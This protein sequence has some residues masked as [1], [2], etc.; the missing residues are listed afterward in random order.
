MCADV[1]L[2]HCGSHP[3]KKHHCTRGIFSVLPPGGF[4]LWL[5]DDFKICCH[6]I[7]VRANNRAAQYGKNE[8]AIVF[9]EVW[10]KQTCF[11]ISGKKFAFIKNTWPYCDFL[12]ILIICAAL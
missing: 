8:I 2:V 12:N 3:E 9:V 4:L 6:I 5:L 10:T 7:L 1:F 11:L